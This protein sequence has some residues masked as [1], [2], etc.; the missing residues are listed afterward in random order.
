MSKEQ[1]AHDR[2][3]VVLQP[4]PQQSARIFR[5]A[6]RQRLET[7]L[8]VVNL[9]GRPPSA[10][11]PWL[12]TA[13]AIIGQ[14]DLTPGRLDRATHLRGVLNVEGN[15]YPNIDYADC[16]RRGIR[17]LGCGPAYA[18]AVAEHALGLAIDLARGITRED[19]AFRAGRERWVADGNADAVLLRDSSIGFLGY[20][21]LG[22]AT[23]RLLVPFGATIRVYDPWLPASVIRTAGLLPAALETVLAES[24]FLFVFATVTAESERLLDATRLDMLPHGARLI[25]VS[26]AAVTDHAALVDRVARGRLQA[27]IDVW[28]VEPAPLDE[29]A[30]SLEGAVLSAHRAGGIPAAFLEI[31]EMVVDDLELMARGLPPV[32]MQVAEPELAG[33]YRNRPVDPTRT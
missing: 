7:L 28:P 33:R 10:L 12:P 19:R 4:E 16:A 13:F 25:L 1:E 3:I 21:N 26:R 9:E 2:P 5:P 30:R 23:H 15:F 20:G 8:E 27:A 18:D 29:P 17:V 22:R 6:T 31:G 24:D 11:D 14:P 32:R